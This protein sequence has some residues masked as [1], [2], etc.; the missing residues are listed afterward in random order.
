[1]PLITFDSP[2]EAEAHRKAHAIPAAV[3]FV[4]SPMG[5]PCW[6]LRW[7]PDAHALPAERPAHEVAALQDPL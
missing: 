4:D 5:E 7:S 2:A 6:L 1:M 3:E